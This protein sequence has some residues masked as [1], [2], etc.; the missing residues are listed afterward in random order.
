MSQTRFVMPGE[1]GVDFAYTKPPPQVLVSEGYTFVVGYV[2]TNPSKDLLNPRD[3]LDVGLGVNFVY[4][5]SALRPNQGAQAGYLD[6]SDCKF[7]LTQRGYPTEVAV[8]VAFDTNTTTVNIA[9]HKAYFEAFKQN[10]A[11]YRIGAYEDTDL[12]KVTNAEETIDW[13]PLAW[14]WSGSSQA[15]A[16]AKA[17]SLGYHV[18][19]EKGFYLNGLYPV[20][21]NIVMRPFLTW[22]LENNMN[23]PIAVV[24]NAEP[25]AWKGNTYPAGNVKYIVMD[26]GRPRR[27]SGPELTARGITPSAAL[28]TPWTNADF[29][30]AGGDWTEPT[31]TVTVPPITLPPFPPVT[32][33][34][35]T[36]W[37]TTAQ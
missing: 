5:T 24:T 13:L 36:K 29:D 30:D 22:S 11:P 8:I 7:K 10:V 16:R 28:G 34:V 2:S 17:I 26:D 20:D 35:P 31:V 15:D 33:N 14:S 6:G 1:R 9:A 25:R 18:F 23:N 12:A 37:V 19:Q 27:A 21:P 3:Y 32:V 4:E